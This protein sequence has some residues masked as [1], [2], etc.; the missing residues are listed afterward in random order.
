MT[1]PYMKRRYRMEGEELA[2]AEAM[3]A[4]REPP[5]PRPAAGV[6]LARDAAAGPEVLLVR[7][8]ADVGFAA[9]AYV[10]PGGTLDAE[11]GE[12][13]WEA[14][15]AAPQAGAFDG[16]ADPGGPSEITFVAAALRELFEETGVLLANGPLPERA[17]LEDERAALVEGRRRFLDIVRDRR[18][19][20]ASDRLVLCARWITPESLSRRYDARFFLAE[21]PRDVE[22]E[23][24]RGELVEHTWAA[25][26]TALEG[27]FDYSFRMMYPTAKTLSWLEGGVSVADWR[28]R[29]L[30]AE[31][32]PVL[33]RLRRFDGEVIPVLPGEPR[34]DER[35]GDG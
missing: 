23:A 33:P 1:D 14:L 9:S 26:R 7:R 3:G 2:A 13:A 19:R 11:D 8:R 24:E 22:I 5:T 28:E 25:P 34:Y 10:F 21:A 18:I 29:F 17:A 27:Y 35:D 32:R 15:L 30:R 4:G 16:A 20:L 12:T 6:I 31:I